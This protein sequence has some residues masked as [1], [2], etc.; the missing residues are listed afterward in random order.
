MKVLKLVFAVLMLCSLT[1]GYSQ[2]Q[3]K[4]IPGGENSILI[5]G[6]SNIHDWEIDVED[7]TSQLS[8]SSQEEN[9]QVVESLSLS[10]PVKSFSSGKS[11]IDKN[12]YKAMDADAHE[13]IRF[14][15]TSTSQLKQESAGVFE[16]IIKG[17][18]TI[19]GTSQTVEIPVSL[20]KKGNGF[21][22]KVEHNLKMQDYGI[23]PPTAL[24]G[25]ITT[26]E[27]VNI[28]FNL[29]HYKS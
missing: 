25:T 10:I 20:S 24:F 27:T 17:N 21:V 5:E 12:T 14:Q 4:A 23:E 22:L 18:L 9:L 3:L 11:K 2:F 29:I 13:S 26:G 28:I 1:V 16:G 6:T 8:L 15:S 19:S 7:F